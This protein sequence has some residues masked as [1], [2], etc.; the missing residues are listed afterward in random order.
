MNKK[1]LLAGLGLAAVLILI[2]WVAQSDTINIAKDTH[3]HAG[4]DVHAATYVSG[5]KEVSVIFAHDHADLSGLGFTDLTLASVPSASGA[6]YE[7]RA[8]N[9]VLWSK[10]EEVT[11]YRGD[12]V[13]FTGLEASHF[14]NEHDV[15]TNESHSEGN[16]ITAPTALNVTADLRDQ[17]WLWKETVSAT[18][19]TTKPRSTQAFTITFRAN[20]TLEGTTDCNRFGG[21][22]T[23]AGNA[24][25]TG[26]LASTKMYC[27]GS[28]ETEFTSI[29]SST[30]LTA[31]LMTIDELRLTTPDSRVVTFV[32]KI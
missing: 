24:I 26:P 13:I 1:T 29:L 9:I 30:T 23:V 22:Y 32:R 18:G 16:E 8:E 31:K 28:Q 7:N 2:V 25:R 21:S 20:G 10:G 27:E 12:E 11:V 4:E 5:A 6:R 3:N 15:P 17:T 14:E 19:S